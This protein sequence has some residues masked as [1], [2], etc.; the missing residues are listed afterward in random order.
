MPGKKRGK[1]GTSRYAIGYAPKQIL[2]GLP[3]LSS[4]SQENFTEKGVTSK[5]Q[6]VTLGNKWELTQGDF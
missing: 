4:K 6:S 2:N 3:T 5:T 1:S